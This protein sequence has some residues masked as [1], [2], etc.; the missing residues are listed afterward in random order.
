MNPV[1]DLLE[2][3]VE[4]DLIFGDLI[5]KKPRASKKK[6]PKQPSISDLFA[7]KRV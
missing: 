4:K 1:C 7:K 6:D 2:P 3:I 5:P